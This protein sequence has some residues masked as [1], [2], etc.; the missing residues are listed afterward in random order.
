MKSTANAF[1]SRL[2]LRLAERLLL[3]A[4]AVFIAGC[5]PSQPADSVLLDRFAR[6]KPQFAQLQKMLV[7]DRGVYMN[8]RYYTYRSLREELGIQKFIGNGIPPTGL[9]FPVATSLDTFQLTHGSTKG[10]AWLPHPPEVLAAARPSP[11]F[12]IT[13]DLDVQH[14]PKRPYIMALRHIAGPWYLYLDNDPFR[15]YW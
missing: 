12:G 13:D 2:V 11:S 9:R 1:G 15:P 4:I 14:L 8:S 3:S 10:Y 7:A 5:A 6:H